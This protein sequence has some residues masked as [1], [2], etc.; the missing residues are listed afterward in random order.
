MSSI[1]LSQKHGVAPALTFCRVCG[2][3]TN[4]LALLGASADQVMR[5]VHAATN[6]QYGS[7]DG[8]SEYEH[9]RIPATE[10]CDECKALLDGK[11]CILIAKDTGEYLKLTKEMVDSLV[12]RVANAKGRVLDF[13]AIRGRI[14]TLNKAFWKAD[15][16]GNVR[17]RDPK[18]WTE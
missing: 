18:E 4:E 9:N 2:K 5:E 6:G 11:G 13:D 8:Y 16:E 15:A 17:L 12:G 10:P 14:C 1:R 3:D 7:K